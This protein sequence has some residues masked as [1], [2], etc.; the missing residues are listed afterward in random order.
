MIQTADTNELFRGGE[1]E[2]EQELEI[3]PP[4]APQSTEVENP[5]VPADALRDELLKTFYKNRKDIIKS[6]IL[7]EAQN[8]ELDKSELSEIVVRDRK[9]CSKAS[10]YR[11]IEELERDGL[12]GTEIIEGKSCL[13]PQIMK[14]STSIIKY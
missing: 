8:R 4:Q 2:Q 9:Y 10:F 1:N 12:L 11:Y 5:T 14:E 6:Q 13:R 7:K 3:E